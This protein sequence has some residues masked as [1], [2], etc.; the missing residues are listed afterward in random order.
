MSKKRQNQFLS[1]Y[2]PVHDRFERFCRAR[3]YGLMDHRDLMNDTLLIAYQKYHSLKSDKAFLSFLIGISIR[4]LSNHSKKKRERIGLNQVDQKD[5]IS[6][7]RADDNVELYILYQALAK[8]P[9]TQKESLILF[10]ISGFSIK[11]IAIL[12]EASESAVKQRLVRGRK[13]LVQ[14]LNHIPVQSPKQ[15]ETL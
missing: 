8:L 11:E 15:K 2:R 7:Y 4:V 14:L 5:L 6:K 3:S 12:H 13:K 9:D 1:L 10:E